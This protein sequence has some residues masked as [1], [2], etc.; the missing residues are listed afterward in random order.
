[1]EE[2]LTTAALLKSL[3]YFLYNFSNFL[4]SSLIL[5]P[6]SFSVLFFLIKGTIHHACRPTKIRN[7]SNKS[8]VPVDTTINIFITNNSNTQLI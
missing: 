1:M 3:G 4:I 6:L 8:G 5:L 7:K 2:Y